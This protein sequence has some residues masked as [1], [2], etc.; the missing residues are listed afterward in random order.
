M[1]DS[2]PA[3]KQVFT[4]A[5][6]QAAPEYLN[7]ERGVEKTI[8]LIEEAARKGVQLIGFPEC[9]IP[10]YPFWAW[11]DAP[12]ATMRYVGVHAANCMTIDGPEVQRIATAAKANKIW[13]VLGFSERSGGSLYIAQLIIADDGTIVAARRK[14]KATL[15]E[16]TIFGEGDG[17]DIKVHD[18][19]LGRLGALC[20]WEHVNPLT[21]YAMFA[22]SEAV[23]V[24][25]WPSF[26]LYPNQAYA[27]GPEVNNALSQVY[28]VEGQCFVVAPCAVISPAMIEQLCD[29]PAKAELLSAGGG[30]AMIWGPDGRPLA[31]P[32]APDEEGLVMA[33]IDLGM[34]P[35]AK[36]GGDPVGHYARPDVMRLLF[37]PAQTS[38][39]EWAEAPNR[40]GRY[41]NGMTDAGRASL[42]E[43]PVPEPLEGSE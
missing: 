1:R 32:L 19:A 39:V 33:E 40:S 7:L 30:H 2:S 14:L 9:W 25:A 3:I 34:I 28:A 13:V 37:N 5:A 41:A 8:A 18:T 27:L 10:G 16:R 12:A 43:F 26:S 35:F 11:L 22:Q 4:A 36:A 17:S 20:C 31:Q 29:T 24:G 23:H 42:S 21:K 6:V 15:I 38:C